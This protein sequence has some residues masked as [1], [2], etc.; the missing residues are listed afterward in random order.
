MKKISFIIE[1]TKERGNGM[2]I[3]RKIFCALGVAGLAFALASCSGGKQVTKDEFLNEFNTKKVE[4]TYEKAEGTFVSKVK[5]EDKNEDV[6]VT[7]KLK[8]ATALGVSAWVNDEG[9]SNVQVLTL[10]NTVTPKT[11]AAAQGNATFYVLSNGYKVTY[12]SS[13]D[14]NGTKSSGS[15]EVVFNECGLVTYYKVSSS[16]TKDGKTQTT[17]QE[18]KHTY[19]KAEAKSAQTATEA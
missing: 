15:A 9:S 10:V 16:Q 12:S 19:K 3:F 14:N 17:F 13:E 1:F 18:L 6:N 2:K 8:Y 5:S 4:S 7:V 11:V